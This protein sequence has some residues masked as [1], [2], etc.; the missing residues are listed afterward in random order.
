MN[1]KDI[2]FVYYRFDFFNAHLNDNEH[3]NNV[4]LCLK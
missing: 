4:L 1:F 3:N 2:K